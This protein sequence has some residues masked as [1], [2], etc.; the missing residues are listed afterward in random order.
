VGGG[1][2]G[3]FS[4]TELAIAIRPVPAATPN[5]PAI[6]VST[7]DSFITIATIDD[8]VAPSA[9][10]T[11]ISLVRSLTVISMMFDTPTTPASRV[12]PP[13]TQLTTTSTR[14]SMLSLPNSTNRLNE[15]IAS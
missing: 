10:R 15:P 13:T 14:N 6:S 3:A 5:R 11:P 9:L 4:S 1:H 12:A 2:D 8:G 7:I